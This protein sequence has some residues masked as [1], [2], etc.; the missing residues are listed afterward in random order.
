MTG[1]YPANIAISFH[2]YTGL[3]N[4]GFT[5]DDVSFGWFPPSMMAST[6]SC[7]AAP[8]SAITR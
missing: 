3:A 4:A 6:R 5:W 7:R 2:L 8:M 1:E